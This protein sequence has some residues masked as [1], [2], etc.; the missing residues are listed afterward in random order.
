MKAIRTPDVARHLAHRE[1]ADDTAARRLF[2]LAPLLAP[3]PGLFER[4]LAKLHADQ[5]S[6]RYDRP[7][8]HPISSC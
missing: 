2:G 1:R 7:G 3:P 6:D 4:I 8:P 5:V